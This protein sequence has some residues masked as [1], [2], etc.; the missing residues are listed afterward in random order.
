MSIRADNPV[1]VVEPVV[2]K[3][4][5]G[6]LAQG[7]LQYLYSEPAQ[8]L[9][10]RHY[11]RVR[12]AEVMH[13]YAATFHPVTLFSVEEVFGSWRQA[14]KNHFDDGAQFDRLISAAGRG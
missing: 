10:A 7:Y 5:D 1:A 2:L 3:K 14:Q 8:E 13:R 11:L 6:E 4:H 9:A 12:S